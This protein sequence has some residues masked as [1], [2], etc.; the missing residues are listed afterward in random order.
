M[1][2]THPVLYAEAGE[3]RCQICGAVLDSVQ[4]PPTPSV[5]L[6]HDTP[7]EQP[8]APDAPQTEASPA[9]AETPQEEPQKPAQRGKKIKAD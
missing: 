3:L 1:T 8:E 2:C 9:P 5:V 4:E 7:P 6:I